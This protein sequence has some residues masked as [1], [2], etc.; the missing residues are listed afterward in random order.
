MK[1]VVYQKSALAKTLFVYLVPI[2]GEHREDGQHLH[3][4]RV[5]EDEGGHGDRVVGGHADVAGAHVHGGDAV[6]IALRG[7]RRDIEGQ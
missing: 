7:L 6:G 3:A 5:E 2:I 4:E 1:R